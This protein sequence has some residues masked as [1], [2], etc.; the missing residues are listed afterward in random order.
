MEKYWVL[1]ES[2][3]KHVFKISS[4]FPHKE[5][6]AA[7]PEK[8]LYPRLQIKRPQNEVTGAK[9]ANDVVSVSEGGPESLSATFRR[10][11]K[12]IGCAPSLVWGRQFSQLKPD[13]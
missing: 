9:K 3:G 10:D 13:R 4:F 1:S 6:S 11:C 8:N 7:V 12:C 5:A 2:G